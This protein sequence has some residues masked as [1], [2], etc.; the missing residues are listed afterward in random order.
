VV[1]E[2]V[3]TFVSEVSTDEGTRKSKDTIG[4]LRVVQGRE[5]KGMTYSVGGGG[6]RGLEM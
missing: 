1:T 6:K 2:D 5:K 4:K 3:Q